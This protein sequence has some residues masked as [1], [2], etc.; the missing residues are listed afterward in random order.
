MSALPPLGW[1]PSLSS[2]PTRR[3]ASSTGWLGV[4]NPETFAVEDA[5][6]KVYGLKAMSGRAVAETLRQH[7]ARKVKQ[8]KTVDEIIEERIEWMKTPVRKPDGEMRSR[9]ESWENVAICGAL[10]AH[11]SARISRAR[12][13]SMTLRRYRTISLPANSA[14]LR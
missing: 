1:R 8:G 4:Y 6:S 13:R 10:S 11:D 5:R 7:K 2:L 3:P 9:L 14:F 12:S